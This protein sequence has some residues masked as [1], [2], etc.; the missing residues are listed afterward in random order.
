MVPMIARAG[1]AEPRLAGSGQ[2]GF[3]FQLVLTCQPILTT[4]PP[5]GHSFGPMP[6]PGAMLQLET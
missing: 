4:W 1:T 3:R 6:V 5:D 2:A